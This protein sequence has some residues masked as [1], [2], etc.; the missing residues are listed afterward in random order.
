MVVK[1]Y[2]DL[3]LNSGCSSG[4]KLDKYQLALGGFLGTG[5]ETN[6]Y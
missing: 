5:P 6:Y 2:G 4:E 3:V 1:W